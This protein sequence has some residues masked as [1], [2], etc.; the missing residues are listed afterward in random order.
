MD[1]IRK[2]VNRIPK[3]KNYNSSYLISRIKDYEVVSFDIYDTLVRRLMVDAKDVLKNVIQ[4][5]NSQGEAELDLDEF[6]IARKKAE[7]IAMKK[8]MEEQGREEVT[9]EEIYKCLSSKYENIRLQLMQIEEKIEMEYVKPNDEIFEVYLWCCLHG[10]TVIFTSDMYLRQTV[11]EAV[12][13]KCGYISYDRLYLSSTIGKKKESGK[14]Y[15]FIINELKIPVNKIVHIGDNLY[16]DF[17]KARLSNLGAIHISTVP[18]RTKF[19]NINKIN[20]RQRSEWIKIQKVMNQNIANSWELDFLYGYEVLGPV[21]YGFCKWLHEDVVKKRIHNI[22]FLS[23]DGGII[24]KA[25]NCLY[26]PEA[27]KNTY[28][29]ASRRTLFTPQLWLNNNV[30]N[31]VSQF[32]YN[33]KW[34]IKKICDWLGLSEKSCIQTWIE[35]GFDTEE[36]ILNERLNS[37]SRFLNFYDKLKD[38]IAINS[39]NEYETYLKYLEHVG[40]RDD[41]AI[42]D[43]GWKGRMQKN[44]DIIMNSAGAN[45]D[46]HGYYVGLYDIVSP[47]LDMQAFISNAMESV[48]SVGEIFEYLFTSTKEGST[49][50]IQC[51]DGDFEPILFEY[52]YEHRIERTILEQIQ[53]G[54]LE[55]IKMF[56]EYGSEFN[57]SG[58]TVIENLKATGRYPSDEMLK[59]FENITFGDKPDYSMVIYQGLFKYLKSPKSLV[60][61]WSNSGWHI[62]FAKKLIKIPFPYYQLC[63]ILKRK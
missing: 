48:D 36:V 17:Y 45:V 6:L 55:F 15:Q 8:R 32:H 62:G 18:Y 58:E 31:F 26:G 61:D 46:I 60:K 11:I 4:I 42:V 51:I 27:I 3:H 39:K 44:L 56:R 30:D 25:Y 54:A 23:R 38:V 50:N 12:L 37:D 43:I 49:K 9:L 20:S 41:V 2:V 29:Y 28:L 24:Q 16:S 21:L 33:F 10:K 7:N 52:E 47:E 22:Y 57:M 59:L 35:C 13:Q 53:E 34:N 5:Y 40:F 19:T 14:L 1:L 63:R